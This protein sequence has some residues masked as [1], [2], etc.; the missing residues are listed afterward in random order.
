MNPFQF[1][2]FTVAHDKCAMKIGTDAVLL[3]AWT[4]CE[5][6]NSIL[7]IGAGT[8]ILALQLAQRSYAEVID[9]IEINDDAYVQAVE[10]FE[11]SPWGDRLFCYHASLQEF[12]AEMDEQYDLIISN[13]PFYVSTFKEGTVEKKRSVARHTQFLTFQELIVS[14][15]K[16]LF[17]DGSCAFVIPYES[18]EEFIAIARESNLFLNRRL[19]VKGTV[20]SPI[21][22]CLLQF[23]FLEKEIES[24]EL[25]IEIARHQYTP[26]YTKLVQDFYLKM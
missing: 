19:H 20:N 3:G 18:E 16:L 6:A 12:V 4:L 14:T 17:E 26:E 15:A 7:D 25:T 11:Q 23:S 1:K 8:G 24:D 13:P 10:N 2:Q 5:Q 9:A 22:R 21:K